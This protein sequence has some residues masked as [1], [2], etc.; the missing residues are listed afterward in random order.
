[1]STVAPSSS[2][3][4]AGTAAGGATTDNWEAHWSSYADSA[5][6]NPAQAYRRRLIFD[7]LALS[8]AP[9]PARVLEL[10]SGQ[11][12]FSRDLVTA[13]PDVSLCGLDLAATGVEIARRKVPGAAFFQQDFTRP[14][15]VPDSYRGWATHAVCSEVLEHLDD[16]AA[17]LAN[18][19]AL[20]APGCRLV[21]TVPAGPM[22][23]FDR[24][25]GHRG[26]FT[27]ERLATTLRAS[28][29]EVAD[30]RGAGFPFFNLYRLAVVAR[31]EKLI[32]DAA[33]DNG[34]GLPLSARATIKMF[35]WLFRANRSAGT[36][37]WQLV[38][39][40]VEPPARTP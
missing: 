7:A 38:A 24:H 10:G 30:L 23:A 4:G 5:A 14:L 27:P 22:S 35:S 21:I 39:V 17:M 8:G 13:H 2:S 26:H 32:Q 31:G 28:G 11:G 25:I 6:A 40:A 3:G 15:A 36:R 37:G 1:M 34:R 9:R 16:P 12:D 29:L 20:M 33:A 19:R 18:V